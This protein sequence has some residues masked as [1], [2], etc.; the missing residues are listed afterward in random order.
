MDDQRSHSG[1]GP[2]EAVSE[3]ISKTRPGSR[4]RPFLP[5]TESCGYPA[6]PARG[7]A[8]GDRLIA[9]IEAVGADA[10]R[11]PTSVNSTTEMASWLRLS[12]THLARKLREAEAPGQHRL[13]GRARPFG[14]VGVAGIPSG[15][16]NGAGGQARDHRQC[17]RSRLFPADESRPHLS[18]H[19]RLTVI[20]YQQARCRNIPRI[21]G[22]PEIGT[23]RRRVI[24]RLHMDGD[25][26]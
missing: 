19:Q 9:G 10:E 11:I 21:C 25:D 1:G 12:R 22:A 26:A 2:A 15:I 6:S 7:P 14:D 13:A 20:R 24:Q 4:S 17:L 5:V 23:R 3:L 16:C 18:K 8:L